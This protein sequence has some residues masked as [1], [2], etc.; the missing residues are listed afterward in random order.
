MTPA[1]A[2]DLLF[3]LAP[4]VS[5]ATTEPAVTQTE[6]VTVVSPV[7]TDA[8][9][10]SFRHSKFK[11]LTKTWAY[12]DAE[13]RLLGYVVRFDSA[14]R[15]EVL[16][17]SW[18]REAAG[19]ASWRWRGLPAPR[20]LYALD[21][22]AQ[23]PDAPVLIVEGEKAADAAQE[24]F[25]DYVSIT[26]S[27]GSGATGKADWAPVAGRRVTLWPD[28]DVAGLRAMEEVARIVRKAGAAAVNEIKLPEDLPEGWDLADEVPPNLRIA[29]LLAAAQPMATSFEWPFGY[30]VSKRGLVWRDP[31]DDEK[32]ELWLAGPFSVAAETRD[33]GGT[34][35]GVL[36]QWLDHDGR[37]H[38]LALPRSALA[39]DA[40]D[41]RRLL[42]DGGLDIAPGRKAREH[43]TALLTSVRSPARMTAT[44]RIGWHGNTFVLPDECIGPDASEP[45]LL[46]TITALSHAFH[47]KGSLPEWQDQI[48]RYAIGNSRLAFALSAAFAAALVQVCDAESGGLHFRGASSIGKTTVLAIAGS[49]WGGAELGGYTKSW[50][51]TSNGLEGVALA[52]C[53]ALLCLD[54]A[55]AN[56]T[57]R[58]RRSRVLAGQRLG[59]ITKRSGWLWAPLGTMEVSVSLVRRTRPC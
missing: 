32:P 7:P 6:K 54:E 37:E 11:H 20:P 18:C 41:A 43:L 45:L 34:S 40:A 31:G 21:R 12:K 1:L 58:G 17:Y 53:D 44:S 55:L 42:L 3:S 57:A 28:A 35:W 8:T 47:Q 33:Q 38:K 10:P 4:L 59:E 50:R 25:P 19:S 30:R 14:D 56:S 24:H 49:V 29:E 27:G 5:E 46:Q 39:G 48:A 23:R 51:A 15:K 13:G 36:L 2:P 52:H 22:L 9:S 26:W 16:P